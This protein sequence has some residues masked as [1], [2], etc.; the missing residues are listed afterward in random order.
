MRRLD[1]HEL[2][3]VCAR[4]TEAIQRLEQLG[5]TPLTLRVGPV[6]T[7]V[8]GFEVSEAREDHHLEQELIDG[9]GFDIDSKGV[10]FHQGMKNYMAVAKTNIL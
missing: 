5:R 7:D 9:G 10:R 1:P 2:V 3:Q 4:R 6:P 8:E